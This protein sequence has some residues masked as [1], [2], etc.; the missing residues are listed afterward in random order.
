[1]ST[2]NKIQLRCRYNCCSQRT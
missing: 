1:M 2:A